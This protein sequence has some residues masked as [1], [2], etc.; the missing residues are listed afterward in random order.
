[1]TW[2]DGYI[3]P[4][5]AFGH[6][7]QCWQ[8]GGREHRVSDDPVGQQLDVDLYHLYPGMGEVNG[9]RSNFN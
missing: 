9:D 8:N 6:K 1:V 4:A 7:C 5:W 3:V 2:P